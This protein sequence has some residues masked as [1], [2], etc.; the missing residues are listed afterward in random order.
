MAPEAHWSAR[1]NP[2]L[3]MLPIISSA[4]GSGA[5]TTT[6]SRPREFAVV[7]QIAEDPRLLLFTEADVQLRTQANRAAASSLREAER[8][9]KSVDS[10]IAQGMLD[11]ALTH[12]VLKTREG[13]ILSVSVWANRLELG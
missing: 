12:K 10:L 9:S 8:S 2:V 5:G 1:T 6:A 3:L 4:S 11:L 13:A 7:T